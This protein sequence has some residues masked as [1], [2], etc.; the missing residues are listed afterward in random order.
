MSISNGTVASQVFLSDPLCPVALIVQILKQGMYRLS[1][2]HC[3]CILSLSFDDD[4]NQNEDEGAA[5]ERKA[6]NLDAKI[7]EVVN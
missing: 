6:S 7:E 3:F 5:F 2:I 4:T 1:Y